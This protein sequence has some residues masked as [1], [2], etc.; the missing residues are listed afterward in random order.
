MTFKIGDTVR[1]LPG[2]G[3]HFGMQSGDT[4]KVT[5]CLA[6]NGIRLDWRRSEEALFDADNY[7]LVAPVTAHKH[8]ALIK[9][10]ADNPSLP[11]QVRLDDRRN[12]SDTE[13]PS[14]NSGFEYRIKPAPKSDVVR[15][16]H[17]DLDLATLYRGQPCMGIVHSQG[18]G[19]KSN[20]ELTFDGE[21]GVLK[22]VKLI[23]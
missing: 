18:T 19:S 3:S 13:E 9:Q 11:I 22:G 8:A 14:W 12:W 20:I 2:K 1:R 16:A 7:E 10:W 5:A 4:A 15:T 23:K 6:R 21:T 17:A